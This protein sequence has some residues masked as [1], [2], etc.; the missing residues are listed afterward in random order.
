M[1]LSTAHAAV[2]AQAEAAGF[3]QLDNSALIKVLG[4]PKRNGTEA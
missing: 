1:P 3:G 4:A 2:L